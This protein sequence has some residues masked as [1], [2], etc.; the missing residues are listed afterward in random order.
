[1]INSKTLG[2]IQSLF[3]SALSP[4]DLDRS[5]NNSTAFFKQLLFIFNFFIEGM[6]LEAT[7]CGLKFFAY[8]LSSSTVYTLSFKIR[9]LW[10]KFH[11]FLILWYQLAPIL[12]THMSP[13]FSLLWNLQIFLDK[14]AE[15]FVLKRMA[16]CYHYHKL[17]YISLLYPSTGCCKLQTQ[18]RH[19]FCP[20][21]KYKQ[22]DSYSF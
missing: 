9:H 4:Q 5:T 8:T 19:R 6:K 3:S 20:W 1:M 2:G 11:F 14:L 7:Y 15:T 13:F 22:S 16:N 17:K 10:A 18:I 21:G 12:E